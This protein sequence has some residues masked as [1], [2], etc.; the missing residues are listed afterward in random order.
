MAAGTI[1]DE[2]VRALSAT[3]V[4]LHDRIDELAEDRADRRRAR[5]QSP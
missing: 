2:Q 1:E 3:F 4:A 5:L